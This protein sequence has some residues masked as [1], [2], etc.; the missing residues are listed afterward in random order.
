MARHRASPYAAVNERRRKREWNRRSTAQLNR[1]RQAR[2]EATVLDY[3][4]ANPK[5]SKRGR[6][7]GLANTGYLASLMAER[8]EVLREARE[9]AE[10]RRRMELATA[11]Y[12]PVREHDRSVTE[13]LTVPVCE[14][15]RRTPRTLAEAHAILMAERLHPEDGA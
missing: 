9:T 12:V 1:Y 11:G 3:D 5:R 6:V 13:S 10:E 4:P 7:H 15:T 2:H 14:H 8:E